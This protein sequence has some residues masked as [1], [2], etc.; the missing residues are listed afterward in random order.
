MNESKLIALHEKLFKLKLED[1]SGFLLPIMEELVFRISVLPIGAGEF[2]KFSILKECILSAN[3]QSENFDTELRE[4]FLEFFYT[5]ASAVDLDGKRF[6]DTW[7]G[8]W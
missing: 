5:A 6:A 7:R 2:Q 4:Y 8:D 3:E 1:N